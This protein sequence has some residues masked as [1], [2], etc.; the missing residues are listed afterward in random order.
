MATCDKVVPYIDLPLQ[1]AADGV[2]KRMR[3]PG[4]RASYERLLLGLR[5]R[6]PERHPADDVHRR[7]PR[8]DRGRLRRAL[9]LRPDGRVRPRRR[10]HLL[11]RGGHRR[12]RPG[13]RRAG[14]DQGRPA[15]QADG[16]PAEDRGPAA[17]PPARASGSRSWSTARRPST[18]WSWTGPAGRPGARDRPDRLPD[19]RRPGSPPSGRLRS[20][21][22]SSTRA[23]TTWWSASERRPAAAR[24]RGDGLRR[25][26]W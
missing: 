20:R 3:R 22:K 15:A 5:E 19:R 11:A 14:P 6:L 10:L 2:L 21:P 24:R 1:H 23:A 7:L 9:R 26:K 13:R 12:P 8:R 18:S 4:S 17:P 16:A 25:Q